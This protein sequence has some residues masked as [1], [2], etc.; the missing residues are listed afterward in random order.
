MSPPVA[1]THVCMREYACVL[2][3]GVRGRQGGREGGREGGK[4]GD[5]VRD[6]GTV[7]EMTRGGAGLGTPH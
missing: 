5:R 6:R 7:R 4:E 2:G 3:R 1:Y